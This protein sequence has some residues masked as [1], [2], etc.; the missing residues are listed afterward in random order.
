MRLQ[1]LQSYDA[2]DAPGN[3]NPT[4]QN[5]I[6]TNKFSVLS[7]GNLR[8]M[9]KH[10]LETLLILDFQ[11]RGQRRRF[12]YATYSFPAPGGRTIKEYAVRLAPATQ[13]AAGPEGPAPP[14]ALVPPQCGV[15]FCSDGM[16]EPLSSATASTEPAAVMATLLRSTRYCRCFGT[17]YSTGHSVKTT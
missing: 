16:L 15:Y 12:Q 6:A 10:V 7:Q 8:P 5:V 3:F 4:A 17:L 14:A 13:A 2:R 1:T 9:S 11:A